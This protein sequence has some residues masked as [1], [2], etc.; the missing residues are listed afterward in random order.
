[1]RVANPVSNELLEEVEEELGGVSPEFLEA[2]EVAGFGSEDVDDNRTIVHEHPGLL[3]ATLDGERVL[4]ASL[5]DLL[6]DLFLDSP[7]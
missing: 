3:L 6:L 1:M 5:G 4:A 7:S 2:V